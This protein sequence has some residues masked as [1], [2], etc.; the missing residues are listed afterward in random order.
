[1]KERSKHFHMTM[2]ISLMFLLIFFDQF[3][4]WLAVK[5]LKDKPAFILIDKVFVLSYLENRG[6]AFGMFQNKQ[7]FFIAIST[8]FILAVVFVL[9]K[10][11]VTRK[12]FYGECVLVVLLSGAVGNM[13]DRVINRYVVD[14][15]YFEL[16]DFPVFNVADIYVTLSAAALFILILF[17]YKDE[18]LDFLKRNRD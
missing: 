5:H 14:F 18:D 9:Y 3:T 12:Y 11:P 7:I 8:V 1:M 13:I 2:D 6:A 4:K 17:V 10:M 15:F 16:I